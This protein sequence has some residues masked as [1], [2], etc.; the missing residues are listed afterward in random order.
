MTGPREPNRLQRLAGAVSTRITRDCS[1]HATQAD[2]PCK[3]S[4]IVG[5]YGPA[6]AQTFSARAPGKPGT[7]GFA[8]QDEHCDRQDEEA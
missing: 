5:Q 4:V 3:A 1:L 2:L 6:A 7:L 8:R